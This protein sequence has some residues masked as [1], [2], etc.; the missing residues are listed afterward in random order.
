[1]ELPALKFEDEIIEFIFSVPTTWSPGVAEDLRLLA[2]EA[3]FGQDSSSHSVEI[4]LTEAEAAAV[5]TLGTES[6]RYGVSVMR[7][8]VAK[9]TDKM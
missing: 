3:G 8:H 7:F 2:K 4:G 5:C 1:M 9:K 6:E